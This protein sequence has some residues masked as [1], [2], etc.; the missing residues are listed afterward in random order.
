MYTLFLAVTKV[1]ISEMKFF[2]D[3]NKV[4]IKEEKKMVIIILELIQNITHIKIIIILKL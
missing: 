4:V 2:K 3:I 1:N